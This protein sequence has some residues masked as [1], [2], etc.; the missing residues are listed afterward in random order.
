MGDLNIFAKSDYEVNV[1]F[2]MCIYSAKVLVGIWCR[3]YE[4]NKK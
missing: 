4:I 2:P 1:W 3:N